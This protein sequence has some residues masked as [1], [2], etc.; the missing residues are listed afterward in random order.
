MNVFLDAMNRRMNFSLRWLCA[1]IAK[2]PRFLHADSEDSDQTGRMS[3]MIWVFAGRTG[4]LLVL[5]CCGS[6]VSFAP[7]ITTQVGLESV[8]LSCTESSGIRQIILFLNSVWINEITCFFLNLKA[9]NKCVRVCVFVFGSSSL[10][11]HFYNDPFPESSRHMTSL[12]GYDRNS[13]LSISSQALDTTK[14]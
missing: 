5:S 6:F 1:Q 12:S 4:H 10:P 2:D 13:V 9:A 11:F 8:L 14:S 7:C 3:K